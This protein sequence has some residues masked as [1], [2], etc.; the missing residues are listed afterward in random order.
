MNTKLLI[1]NH[2]QDIVMVALVVLAA[3][4]PVFIRRS[5][6]QAILVMTVYIASCS[7]AWSI[8]GGMLGQISLGH[9]SFA[10]VG[11]YIGTVLYND[12][13]VSPWISMV[14]AFGVV[15][16]L[17]MLLMTPCFGLK[18]TYFSLTTIA[19]GEAFRNIFTNWGRVGAGQGLKMEIVRKGQ[20][21]FWMLA[22]RNKAS[23]FYVGLA[24]LV[25]FYLVIRHIDRSK[26]GYGLKTIREDEGTAEAIGINPLHYK[27]MAT[28]LSTG[29]VAVMGVFYAC[30][31]RYISPEL[32]L[33]N[34]SLEFVLPAVIGGIST[35]EGPAIGALLI[36]PL[37]QYLNSALGSKLPGSNLMVYALILIAVVLF[38]PAGLLGHLKARQQQ[39]KIAAEKAMLEKDAKED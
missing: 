29:M 10:A 27:M 7:L 30:Y 21:S 4:L 35:V 13:G 25:V 38:R 32:M 20:E 23:Y 26:L 14:V 39:K 18:G 9:A 22:F 16:V 36:V 34:K 19:F 24:L 17:V 12:F 5:Y 6:I 33:Q 2:R 3:L 1:K 28:F 31:I 37:S 11:A 8:L 15:G